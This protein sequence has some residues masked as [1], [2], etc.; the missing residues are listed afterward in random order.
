MSNVEPK[1]VPGTLV[2]SDSIS[3]RGVLLCTAV[4]RLGSN[5]YVHYVGFFKDGR[6]K[7]VIVDDNSWR[8]HNETYEKWMNN[9]S[10]YTVVQPLLLLR[11][12]KIHGKAS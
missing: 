4:Y 11:Y 3:W 1:I 6:V 7:F 12:S 8:L 2:I 5:C 9:P 10:R